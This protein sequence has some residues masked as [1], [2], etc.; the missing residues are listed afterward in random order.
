VPRVQLLHIARVEERVRYQ[1]RRGR[2]VSWIMRRLARLEGARGRLD[3]RG[4]RR[5]VCR[6][7]KG[8]RARG[9]IDTGESRGGVGELGGSRTCRRP[10]RPIVG[11]G[12]RPS[13]LL[14]TKRPTAGL[15]RRCGKLGIRTWRCDTRGSGD[16]RHPCR[17][18]LPW[19]SDDE[20]ARGSKVG[21]RLTKSHS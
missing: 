7:L 1:R 19:W 4:K 3:A 6:A 14:G 18:R 20:D 5:Q 10:K 9:S 8:I 2:C 15:G 21:G 17:M 16:C 11:S 12:E 13:V